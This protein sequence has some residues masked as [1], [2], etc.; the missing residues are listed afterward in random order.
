[1][2]S[3]VCFIFALFMA[4]P[5][6]SQVEPSATGGNPLT[7]DDT[8][9]MTPPPVSGMLYPSTAGADARTNY[10]ATA[11][12][13]TAAYLD[14][15]LPG[16]GTQPLSATTYSVL[17]SLE[18]DRTTP[19]QQT[20]FKYTPMFVFYQ[21]TNQPEPANQLD[22]VDQ[23][24]SLR[25]VDHLS[26]NV[27]F[28][29]QDFFLRTSNIFD[30]AYPFSEGGLSGTAQGPSL[31]AIAPFAEELN[32][33]AEAAISYQFARNAMVGVGGFYSYFDFPNSTDAVG[34][35]N[36]KGGGPSAFYSRRFL[37]MQYIGVTY[38][39]SRIVSGGP[40]SPI[41]TE[42][43]SLLPFYTLYFNSKF[44]L[45]LSAGA[46]QATVTEDKKQIFNSWSPAA[47]ASFG[48]QSRRGDIAVS[49]LHTT[50]TGSGL[51]G[52]DLSNSAD[53]SA[54]WKLARTW[55]WRVASSYATLSDS[56]TLASINY[57]SGNTFTGETSVKHTIGEHLAL[58]FGYDRLQEKYAG[59][60]A[61]SANPDS[62]RGFV[63]V[64]YLLTRPLGR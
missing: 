21:P 36:S 56:T 30:V 27:A 12:S 1:M 24:M 34:L 9:M 62:D 39:Y 37:R 23:N 18:F 49:Y 8:K 61:I 25:L 52:P 50:A 20:A 16:D 13:V 41:E 2:S 26:P 19:R 31:A 3:H 63:T 6:L 11:V 40:N 60:P 32:D 7:E 14:N 17:P 15:V 33:S 45:S 59:I 47:T 28:S 48:W 57:Q 43:S 22:T 5:A 58:E 35:Y 51:I 42:L 54:D 29:L 38:F 53:V 10:L 46:Q 55:T 64:S 4:V 44:S